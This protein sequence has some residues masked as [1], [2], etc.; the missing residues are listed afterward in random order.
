MS[1]K[2]IW[3]RVL[4]ITHRRSAVAVL[5]A[6]VAKDRT[7]TDLVFAFG[8]GTAE[9]ISGDGTS[10]GGSGTSSGDTSGRGSRSTGSRVAVPVGLGLIHA[11]THG[12]TLEATCLEGLDHGDGQVESGELVDVVSDGKLA[13][14]GRVGRVHSVAEVVLRDLDP[15]AS[16]LVV[17]IGI[18]VEVG[19]DIAE[20]L[21]DVLT[22]FV[23]RRVRGAHVGRVFANDVADG[24]LVLDHLVVHLSLGDGGEILVRPSVRGN[25][26]TV[27]DHTIDDIAPLLIDSTLAKVDTGDEESGLET[28]SSEL[29]KNLVSVDVW[30]VIVGDGNSSWLAAHVDTSTTI[31]NA[32]FLR[33]SIIASS[34]SSRSLV[35]IAGRTVVKQAVRS[36]AVL[37][38]VSTVSLLLSEHASKQK[39][40]RLT[41]STGAAVTLSTLSVTKVGP[42]A[43]VGITT[44]TS[45][46]V[47]RA[48]SSSS[49]SST[50]RG[51]PDLHV[52]G[53]AEELR[54]SLNTTV[55]GNE[56]GH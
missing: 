25:L 22:D 8:T 30:T 27:G 36:V 56:G 32:A 47:M 9:S 33:A 20:L 54:G 35:G 18:Q 51:R 6:A 46:Q 23:T 31:L 38:S 37:R 12:D 53:H 28:G 19:D 15:L 14:S 10:R 41:Y 5:G 55:G 3:C 39:T 2:R 7:K 26:V 17:I 34:G 45:V 52:A 50:R 4:E 11:F 40:Q 24:H 21:H 1:V 48:L 44:L 16:E 13:L 49:T 42:A 43:V 29:V